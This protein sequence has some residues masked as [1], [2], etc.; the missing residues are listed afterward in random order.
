MAFDGKHRRHSYDDLPDTLTVIPVSLSFL[1]SICVQ[2]DVQLSLLCGVLP[3]VLYFHMCASLHK[4]QY[5]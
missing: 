5:K 1:S 3:F 4:F 2:K